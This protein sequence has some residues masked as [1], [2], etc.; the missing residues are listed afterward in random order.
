MYDD[1]Q[2][3]VG[4]SNISST[5]MDLDSHIGNVCKTTYFQL[6]NISSIRNVLSDDACA[7][8]IHALV[9][10]RVDYCNSL[11][12]GLPDSSLFRLQKILNTAARILCRISK[13]DHISSTLRD[14]HWLPIRQRITFK[15]L[16]LTYQAY[17][18]TA[19]L[20]LCDMITPY[21]NA[22]SLRSD[23]LLLIKPFEPAPRLKT[24]GEKCFQFA[25][26]KEWNKLPFEIRTSAS[27][28]IF[29]CRVK[30]HLFQLAYTS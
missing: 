14:L 29:K 20:Y 30:T 15:I 24:Y 18:H 17:H 22:R 1:I 27:L 19:P 3:K 13:H 2:L 21:S 6:R 9:T 4:N 12:Y 7:Q 10:V 8:L 23:N 11:L 26:P 5:C 16:I 28:S 25:G